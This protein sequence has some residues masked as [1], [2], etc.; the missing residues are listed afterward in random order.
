MLSVGAAPSY[1][2]T[3]RPQEFQFLYILANL[4]HLL[5]VFVFGLFLDSI[6]PSGCAV[7]PLLWSLIL[8][9][10]GSRSASVSDLIRS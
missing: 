4:C 1:V 10:P 8:N 5:G 2:P 7:T 3:N 9:F 6:H